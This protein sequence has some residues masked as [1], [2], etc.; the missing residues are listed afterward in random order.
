MESEVADDNPIPY[1]DDVRPEDTV[2][3]LQTVT[4]TLSPR[5]GPGER[6]KQMKQERHLREVCV[7]Q[8][9]L[10]LVIGPGIRKL[11]PACG[12][13]RAVQFGAPKGRR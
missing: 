3:A 6:M 10:R 11:I 7:L 4:P 2:N 5:R 12:F 1:A 9:E 8:T 13:R